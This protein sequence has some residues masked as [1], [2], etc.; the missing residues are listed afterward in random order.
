[1]M[2]FFVLCVAGLWGFHQLPVARFPDIAFPMTTVTITQPGA[3]PSQL[4]TEV[5][6]KV[7]D[8]VATIPN[9]K[10]VMSS[11]TEG[12]STTSI[13]FELD[14]DLATAL[15]DTRDAVTRI[16]TDLPQDIQEPVV[17]KVD[18]GGSLMTYAVVAPAL[19]ADELSWFVDR[20]IS[21]AHVRR[22]GR[23]AWSRA[24]AASSAR[25]ASTWI[26]TRCRPAAS[27]PAR[28][29]SNWRASRSSAPAARPSSDGAQQVDP[30]R[31][32]RRQTRSAA[33]L[34]DQPARWPR[35]APV[36]AGHGSPMA[37][38]TRPRSRCS[39]A[40]R[41]SAFS[42]SRTRGSERTEGRRRRRGG[43]RETLEAAHPGVQFRLVTTVVEETAALLR[44]VDDDAVG[45]RAAGA[46]GGLA[47]PARLARDLGVGAWRCRCRS[48][49]PSR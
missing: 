10:R 44:L 5:T 36:G 32:H 25:C 3:S 7:E 33:R 11:V 27:P 17:A 41:W 23:G 29:P 4:E 8:S 21:K 39:T 6:R 20:E 48:S 19:A 31:R 38:P 40:S 12:V 24:S 45:R 35:G 18:I 37:P 16:R 14:T 43:A 30:H 1:M 13:E 26:R 28:S 34:L 47:V 15:D 2:V 22:A 46:A 42:L 9:I 49:R